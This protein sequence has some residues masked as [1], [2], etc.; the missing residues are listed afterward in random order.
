MAD[1]RDEIART[2][3]GA[4][5]ARRRWRWAILTLL[6]LLALAGWVWHAQRGADAATTYVTE[7]AF[8]APLVVTVTATGTVQ[9]TTQVAVSSELSG[10]LVAV[11]A[12]YNDRVRVGQVLARLDD[13]KLRAQVA[14]AEAALAAARAG[15]TQAEATERETR[16]NYIAQSALDQRGV[17]TRRDFVGYEALFNR[18]VAAT[19]IAKADLATA[20]AN[21]ALQQADLAKSVIRS[22]ID[23]IVLDRQAE[24]G[25]I[26]A[27]SLNTPTLFTLAEDLRRMELRVDIDE[28]DIGRVAVG[29]P[30][31]FTVDAYDGR[32]FPATITQIRF[33]PETTEGVVTYKAVL[34]VDNAE[35]LL[36]PGMTATAMI[37]VARIADALQV[38]NAAL[39]YAPPVQSP[40]ASRGGGLLG[41][42]LPRRPP[43]AAGTVPGSGHAVWVLRDG[44]PNRVAIVP[45]DSDGRSTALRSGDLAEGDP[46][47]LEQSVAN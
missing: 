30:A 46:V 15:V 12:D 10:T 6:L 31:T 4:K 24:E 35:L 42:I 44:A 8:R 7:P 14:N 25:Q 1:A 19:L 40:S 21:L 5:P 41:L 38:P 2:L 26:V 45:G 3:A 39:R 47:I 11:E 43:D 17:S 22:P 23:G 34:S 9:P 13:T 37:T 20:E 32:S 27:S 29:N 28:A 18:A 33:A 36:R 16:E